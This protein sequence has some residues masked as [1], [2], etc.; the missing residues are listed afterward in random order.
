MEIT[1][2]NAAR[3]AWN[4]PLFDAIFNRRSRRMSLGAE[5]P[6]GATKY[7]S[8]KPPMPLDEVE[9]AL[10][11]QAGTGISGMNLSDLPYVYPDGKSASGNTM[12]QFTGRTWSSPCGSHGTE[13]IYFNDSGSYVVTLKDERA[14]KVRQY[15]TEDDREKIVTQLRANRTKILDHRPE[16]PRAYPA[17][18]SFNFWDSNIEGSTVFLPVINNT[19]QYING[20][21]LMCGWADGG[22]YLI[23]DLNGNRPAG[24]ERWVGEGLL[25]A[26]RPI[27]LSG[28]GFG[29]EVE[30]AFILHNIVLAEQA[31][32]LGGWIHAGVSPFVLQDALGFRVETPAGSVFPNPV[33]IDGVLE[34]YC[35]PYYKN[36]DAAVDAVVEAK[37]GA[38]GIYTMDANREAPFLDKNEF[39][40]AVP[41]YSEKL[42]Q[43]VKDISNYIYETFGR[44]P[45]TI[46]TMGISPYWCQAH[47]LDL[48]FY[49]KFYGAEAYTHTQA[50]HYELWHGSARPWERMK[51]R[52]LAG[53]KT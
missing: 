18:L 36:M 7:K 48:D 39:I 11:V 32:G 33:G 34:G 10:L 30:P 13:L 28:G 12:I 52:E 4:Y 23:D 43:C 35:P 3:K 2:N 29:Q 5:I 22:A 14:E 1:G 21:L 6:G 20:L 45:A 40:A 51:E 46:P 42:V 9:E 41:R 50:E 8:D 16:H 15:E 38:Q 25:D 47:H 31:M 19:W 37:F 17:M 26:N 49:D 24:C 27:P 44:F 53:A